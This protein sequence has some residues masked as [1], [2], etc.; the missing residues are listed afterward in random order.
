MEKL[1]VNQFRHTEDGA[2][3][4]NLIA[5]L[6]DVSLTNTTSSCSSRLDSREVSINA[7]S[8]TKYVGNTLDCKTEAEE[9][10]RENITYCFLLM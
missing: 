9:V 2:S 10:Q 6:G 8:I 7:L 1:K 4:I 3:H 5:H